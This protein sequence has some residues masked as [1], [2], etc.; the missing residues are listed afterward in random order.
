[1]NS[2][3]LSKWK[4]LDQ[5]LRDNMFEIGHTLDDWTHCYF[6]D[7]FNG[8]IE[9]NIDDDNCKIL[10]ENRNLLVELEGSN[11]NGFTL[12]QYLIEFTGK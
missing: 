1:M 3:Y 10:D 12:S 2:N 8:S 9:Y 11:L 6:S 7:T 5:I 4:S